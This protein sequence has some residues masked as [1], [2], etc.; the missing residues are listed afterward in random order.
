MRLP[1]Q[2]PLAKRANQ[3]RQITSNPALPHP[4]HDVTIDLF[5]TLYF[6]QAGNPIQN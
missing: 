2:A 1:Q 4:P 5:M 3:T 6:G